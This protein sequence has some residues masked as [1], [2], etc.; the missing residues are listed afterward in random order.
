MIDSENNV[1]F[2]RI[3]YIFVIFSIVSSGYIV[4]ILSCQMRYVLETNLYFR[5]LIGILMIFVLIMTSGGWS[6]DKKVDD[7]APTN[8]YNGNVIDTMIM[9]LCI[10]IIFLFSSKS[11]FWP[12]IVFF[13]ILLLLYLINTQRE[14][15]NAR[16]QITE[17]INKILLNTEYVLSGVGGVTLLYGFVDYVCYQKE[18]Y[19]NR[20][21]WLYFIL[22]RKRCSKIN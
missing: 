14:F 22:G 15:W 10:Y 21:N 9:A 1:Y 12:N 20:F 2:S 13:S 17:K 18:E 19:G 5:H 8:W 11:R 7:E 6:F 3:A 16:E 4:D